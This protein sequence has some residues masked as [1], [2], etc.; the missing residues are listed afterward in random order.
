[1]AEPGLQRDQ[2]DL[3]DDVELEKELRMALKTEPQI[4]L[5]KTINNAMRVKDELANNQAVKTIVRDMWTNVAEFFDEIVKVGSIQDLPHDHDL[6]VAHKD[7]Q[8]NFRAVAA[9]N[10][11]FKE[12]TVAEQT[13]LAEDQ[14]NREQEDTEL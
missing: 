6:V 7:M 8:A 1:M 10:G 12:A 13:L 9:I 11:I 14:M 3:Y 4:D 2:S 5:F